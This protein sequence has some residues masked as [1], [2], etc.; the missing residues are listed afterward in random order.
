MLIIFQA[1][2]TSYFHGFSL[3]KY[4]VTEHTKIVQGLK[5]NMTLDNNIKGWA[6]CLFFMR[7]HT[8]ESKTIGNSLGTNVDFVVF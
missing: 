8:G 2:S 6:M 3:N 4:D 5:E 7:S 1:W